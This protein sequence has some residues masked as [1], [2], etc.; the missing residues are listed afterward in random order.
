VNSPVAL[1]VALLAALPVVVRGET[2][3]PSQDAHV[4][5][6]S[7]GNFGALAAIT[8][9]AAKSEGLVQF[10]LTQLPQGITGDQIWK[11]TL[12]LFSNHVG[13]PG[14]VDFYA[15]NGV[16]TESA[17]NAGNAPAAGAL[18]AASVP[19]PSA[20]SY[21][22]VDVTS[23]VRDWINGVAVNDGFLIRASTGGPFQFDSKENT[24]TSHPAVLNVSL[25]SPR[26]PEAAVQTGSGSIGQTGS[27]S[28]GQT[29]SASIGQ[30]GEAAAVAA[31]VRR[32]TTPLDV[33]PGSND[34]TYC[35]ATG[36]GSNAGTCIGSPVPASYTGLTI[37]LRVDAPNTGPTTINVSGL[38]P[39]PI[40]SEGLPLAPATLVPGPGAGNLYNLG[41]DGARL[42]ITTAASISG[43]LTTNAVVY[44]PGGPGCSSN[45][46]FDGQ[47]LHIGPATTALDWMSLGLA[48][49]GAVGN[50]NFTTGSDLNPGDPTRNDRSFT[51]GYNTTGDGGRKVIS[52]PS[53]MWRVEDYYHPTGAAT[54]LESH[55]QYDS[56]IN[57]GVFTRPLAIQI[58]RGTDVTTVALDADTTTFLDRTG[59]NQLFQVNARNSVVSASVPLLL[60]TNNSQALRQ[61]N[62]TNTGSITLAYVDSSNVAW[63]GVGAA[64]TRFNS[65]ILGTSVFQDSAD[66]RLVIKTATGGTQISDPLDI[67]SQNNVL[68]AGVGRDGTWYATNGNVSGN[69]ALSAMGAGVLHTSS[70]GSVSAA[71][72]NLASADVTGV[73]PSTS[74]PLVNNHTLFNGTAPAVSSCGTGSSTTRTSND[75]AGTINIGVGSVTSCTLTFATPFAFPPSCR[76]GGNL[77]TVTG[78]VSSVSTT[79]ITF[80]FSGG[81]GGG[82][83][84]YDC[85]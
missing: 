51:I 43:C 54:Y 71:P 4:E 56:L 84:Y 28:I 79:A 5:P 58:N 18:V 65:S 81:I 16:W 77:A 40:Y 53:F 60:T 78:G 73:L 26:R 32:A 23:A 85:F 36:I 12:T 76:I 31:P 11:A 46:T 39:V 13:L 42:N 34:T 9:D 21:V 10:D 20:N 33:S 80:S 83:A 75:N 38:G 8:V 72:V 63:Y 2:L 49:S 29:G 57:P 15:A 3:V 70:T 41:Y 62:S 66:T 55:L 45:L 14:A 30:A 64:G 17:V 7:A 19:V 37:Y 47:E 25:I 27:A 68:L 59:V 61:T 67:I 24:D 50:Y 69:F 82:Q 6:L 48:N 44:Y 52:E 74:L 1:I 22:T 35:N